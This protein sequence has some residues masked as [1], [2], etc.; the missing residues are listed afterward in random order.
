MRALWLRA[1]QPPRFLAAWA[2]YFGSAGE[3]DLRLHIAQ[4]REALGL[5]L[6]QRFVQVLP[7]LALAADARALV[8]LVLSTL[9]GLGVAR[10][11]GH[12]AHDEDAQLALLAR[13]VEMHCQSTP[14]KPRPSRRT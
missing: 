14:V 3:P 4:Q 7:E 12:Q 2:V 9:R 10:L 5:A 8:Q 11:F 6:H 1:Y 13:L